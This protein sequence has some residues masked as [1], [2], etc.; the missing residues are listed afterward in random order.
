MSPAL[1]WGVPQPPPTLT[2]SA[3]AT[4]C[5][6]LEGFAYLGLHLFWND[7]PK[8]RGDAVARPFDPGPDSVA[9]DPFAK[10]RWLA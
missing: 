2:L 1:F 7:L 4:P 9:L 8:L 5:G 3:I 10:R 6:R